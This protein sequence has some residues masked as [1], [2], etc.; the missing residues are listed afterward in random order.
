VVRSYA[1]TRTRGPAPSSDTVQVQTVYLEALSV[2]Q[3]ARTST[4]GLFPRFDPE[5]TTEAEQL[6]TQVAERTPPTS[7]L[8]LEA[9]FYLGKVNLAQGQVD[10]AR[11]HF[12][13]VVKQDGRKAEEARRILARLQEL[14]TD[15]ADGR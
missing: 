2:L 10:A 11:T 6:L 8:A 4:L 7:F 15:A 5:R 14:G 9:Q 12:R 3:E 1:D 13:R